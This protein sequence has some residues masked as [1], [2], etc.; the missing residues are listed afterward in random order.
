MVSSFLGIFLNLEMEAVGGDVS[1]VQL[2]V[3]LVKVKLGLDR[4]F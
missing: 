4:N 2:T 1:G 3:P